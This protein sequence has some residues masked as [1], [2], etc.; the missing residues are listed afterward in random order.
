MVYTY[1]IK[2]M[3]NNVELLGVIS[4]IVHQVADGKIPQ[5]L[6][7]GSFPKTRDTLITLPNAPYNNAGII[8]NANTSEPVNFSLGP[9]G[10]IVTGGINRPGGVEE[11]IKKIRDEQSVARKAAEKWRVEQDAREEMF[12]KTYEKQVEK[13]RRK[14]SK[15]KE[16]DENSRIDTLNKIS[17]QKFLASLDNRKKIEEVF[18]L[19]K[20]SW[21]ERTKKIH[22]TSRLSENPEQEKVE[23]NSLEELETK[24]KNK[25][26]GYGGKNAE[27]DLRLI[28]FI[29]K[30][31]VEGSVLNSVEAGE[32]IK[33]GLEE[34][35]EVLK[36]RYNEK[37]K[38]E[39]D[40]AQKLENKRKI[41]E[42]KK[43]DKLFDFVCT[44]LNLEQFGEE[45]ENKKDELRKH[46]CEYLYENKTGIKFN[47][48]IEIGFYDKL[49]K[50]KEEYLEKLEIVG[51]F[52]DWEKL[53][54]YLVKVVQPLIILYP[55]HKENNLAN[56]FTEEVI[57][58]YWSRYLPQ[59]KLEKIISLK[60][61]DETLNF[62]I[63][64]KDK[65]EK[66]LESKLEELVEFLREG[67]LES[68]E[69]EENYMEMVKV[70]VL[71]SVER[72]NKFFQRKA[73][74]EK[75]FGTHKK[76]PGLSFKG[77]EYLDI[78]AL[79]ETLTNEVVERLSAL[80]KEYMNGVLN[81]SEYF[82]GSNYFTELNNHWVNRKKSLFTR[83]FKEKMIRDIKKR[84]FKLIAD[85]G[86]KYTIDDI[87]S[88]DRLIDRLYNHKK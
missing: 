29:C 27:I 47:K 17:K 68:E 69:T 39:I 54:Q 88:I 38:I 50:F 34:S 70:K 53:N 56:C 19:K 72:E 33:Y 58:E 14:R 64:T 59:D 77:K 43:I 9:D 16:I 62:L 66:G 23:F 80:K 52:F 12:L 35:L 21:Q 11:K 31:K 7:G 45:K 42:F 25:Y 49:E 87:N 1:H 40:E 46:I 4:K 82:D 41:L 57:R 61:G 10:K 79:M 30:K 67:Y 2:A 44:Y 24:L 85:S 22:E 63:I 86:E 55:D 8:K 13:E 15:S 5:T 28:M 32:I 60:R 81:L 84:G 3:T 18:K 6:V 48:L 26:F 20:I 74:F 78:D 71:A 65:I 76:I 75:E 37:R 83:V 51:D 73:E 36:K